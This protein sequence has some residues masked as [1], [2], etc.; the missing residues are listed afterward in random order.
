MSDK[1]T[2]ELNSKK[3]DGGKTTIA[4]N[5]SKT[6]SLGTDKIALIVVSQSSTDR[7]IIM[8]KGNRD[9]AALV[10]S[11]SGLSITTVG[12]TVTVLVNIGWT[13]ELIL[14]GANWN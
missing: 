10:G 13:L 14:I 12:G 6:F 11:M 3:L 2:N 8:V 9:A 1:I 5:Q 7:S 4:N